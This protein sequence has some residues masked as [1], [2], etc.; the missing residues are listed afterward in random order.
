M[1]AG[2][3]PRQNSAYGL[4]R[5]FVFDEVLIDSEKPRENALDGC[6]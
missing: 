1:A 6:F 2:P 5:N 3:R 4:L